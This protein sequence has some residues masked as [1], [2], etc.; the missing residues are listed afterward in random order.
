MPFAIKGVKMTNEKVREKNLIIGKNYI[1]TFIAYDE[2]II[3]LYDIDGNLV[4][5]KY[6]A[7]ISTRNYKVFLKSIVGVFMRETEKY[8]FFDKR[9]I[10]KKN[11]RDIKV[12]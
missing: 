8:L 7:N 11:I 4:E 10:L 6:G 12:A 9:K 1:I 2:Q 3:P 5:D